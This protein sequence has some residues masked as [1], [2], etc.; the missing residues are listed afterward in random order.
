VKRNITACAGTV[1]IR[2][3]KEPARPSPCALPMTRLI[4]G[5]RWESAK[6]SFVLP[7]TPSKNVSNFTRGGSRVANLPRGCCRS[8]VARIFGTSGR[9]AATEHRRSSRIAGGG[10]DR[11]RCT[12]VSSDRHQPIGKTVRKWTVSAGPFPPP[13][14]KKKSIRGT[15]RRMILGRAGA[16]THRPR[17]PRVTAKCRVQAFKGRYRKMFGDMTVGLPALGD[18]GC[19]V[20]C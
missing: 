5:F 20:I 19:A 1:G 13:K 12:S 2:A 15:G 3:R 9:C 4:N 18:G 10:R 8:T 6:S 17:R 11:G 7:S 14:K 16:R